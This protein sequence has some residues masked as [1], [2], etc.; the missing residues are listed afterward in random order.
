MG[1]SVSDLSGLPTAS[2]ASGIG[3]M[4]SAGGSAGALELTSELAGCAFDSLS[5]GGGGDYKLDIIVATCSYYTC[6]AGFS[7]D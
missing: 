5:A 2:V 3:S 4:I 1:D 6:F 7:G